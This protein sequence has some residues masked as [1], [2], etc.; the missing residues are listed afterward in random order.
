LVQAHH[1]LF[2]RLRSALPFDITTTPTIAT[3]LN[4]KSCST[5]LQSQSISITRCLAAVVPRSTSPASAT[6]PALATSPTNSNGTFLKPRPTR[7]SSFPLPSTSV[8]N[9]HMSLFRTTSSVIPRRA[10]IFSL[11][12]P[13]RVHAFG[14]LHPS[15]LSHDY[16]TEPYLTTS[17]LWSP[18]SLR[19][20]SPALSFQQA[21]STLAPR[22]GDRR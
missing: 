12:I 14:L 5:T 13:H 1:R 11:R 4:C 19:Y 18:C 16:S 17:K 22:P 20:P 9:D 21:V 10:A 6:A 2:R 15:L 7:P 3:C 8:C